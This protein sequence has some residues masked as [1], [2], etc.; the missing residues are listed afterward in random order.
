[1]NI[2]NLHFDCLAITGGIGS[3]KSTVL[4]LFKEHQY[5]IINADDVA[6]QLSRTTSPYYL[7][8]AKEVDQH[9]GTHYQHESE[10]SR[11]HLRSILFNTPNGF[12]IISDL[13][14]P[15]IVQSMYDM[16]CEN[17]EKQNKIVFEVPLLLETQ[18]HHQFSSILAITCDINIK[19]QRIKLRNP[20]LTDE[21]IIHRIQ[22]QS[23]DEEKKSIAHY[24]IDNSGTLEELK[25][26]FE[27]FLS[28]YEKKNKFTIK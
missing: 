5:I 12:K 7:S 28:I 9:F 22:I 21:E 24:V 4:Q 26:Q 23:S 13:A 3:G 16:Y 6:H 18:L 19:K 1:M 14:T 11:P 2:K 8:Y 15:Y 10:I 20:D 17:K 25:L 27:Q